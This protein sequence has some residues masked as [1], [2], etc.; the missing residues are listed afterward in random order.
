M[1]AACW[2]VVPGIILLT[3]VA[4]A[5]EIALSVMTNAV[6]FRPKVLMICCTKAATVL[7][8][9]ES[10]VSNGLKRRH[11]T[12]SLLSPVR[13]VTR[14]RRKKLVTPL[15]VKRTTKST[16]WGEVV[17]TLLVTSTAIVPR[18]ARLLLPE[19]ETRQLG[20][21]PAPPASALRTGPKNTMRDP[22][23]IKR[24]VLRVIFA[25]WLPDCY[26]YGC[27]MNPALDLSP[28][29]DGI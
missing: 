8:V 4:S 21:P 22:T 14:R 12:S 23:A 26:F 5:L 10:F 15:R 9:L 28:Y 7:C 17:P 18:T 6:L 27:R 19:F 11:T 24:I 13:F 20:V 16:S 3:C 2:G 29:T 25:S 1:L